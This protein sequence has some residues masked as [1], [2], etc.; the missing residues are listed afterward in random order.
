MLHILL[1][2]IKIIG[3]ILAAILGILVLLVCI[4]LFVPVRYEA[5]GKGEGPPESLKVKVRVTWLLHLV[6]VDIYYTL[7]HSASS[8][9]AGIAGYP[10][11]YRDQR[12]RWRV[13][14]AWIKKAGGRGGA[15]EKVPAADEKPAEAVA[16]EKPPEAAVDEKPPEAVADGG[17][18]GTEAGNIADD[19]AKERREETQ[20]Y[21][22]SEERHS[23]A[24]ESK[25]AVHEESEEIKEACED[26]KDTSEEREGIGQ[27]IQ[28]IYRKIAAW[29]QKIKCTFSELCDRIKALLEK[30]DKI[31]AFIEDEVHVDAFVRV[32]KELFRCLKC[33]KP[34]KADVKVIYGFE[35][36]YRTGQVLAG[37]SV[38]YPF[39]G[40][41]TS[42]TPDFE[43][44]V[45]KGSAYIKGKLYMWHIVR[46]CIR[47]ILSKNIRTTYKHIKNF[48]L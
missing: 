8:E 44:R 27:K 38:L 24:L 35:D 19:I 25:K 16:D 20:G 37:V 40:E 39:I 48:E 32:K 2:I 21:E 17:N 14:A 41:Y 6:A 45:L 28:G 34:K 22:N 5:M 47:L 3:I 26:E 18:A 23:E 15:P 4:V 33:L 11:G 31:A 30:K 43:H 12:L 1:L 13:R 10:D 36:P 7:S 29:F 42:I 9:G 46:M